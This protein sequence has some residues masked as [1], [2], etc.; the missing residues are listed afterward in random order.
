MLVA[1][2]LTKFFQS[3]TVLLAG[4]EIT[5]H[6]TG[7]RNSPNKSFWFNQLARI[8]STNNFLWHKTFTIHQLR[9]NASVQMIRRIVVEFLQTRARTFDFKFPIWNVWV[10]FYYYYYFIGHIRT[11]HSLLRAGRTSNEFESNIFTG[12]LMSNLEQNNR[13][14]TNWSKNNNCSENNIFF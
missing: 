6:F 13:R 3:F 4:L 8:S 11:T 1:R 7:K 5:G 2:G 9:I 12:V 14:I 10:L